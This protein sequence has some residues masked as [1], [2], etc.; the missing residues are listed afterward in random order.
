M[1]RRTHSR[2]TRLGL[3]VIVL[4]LT[5]AYFLPK[6]PWQGRSLSHSHMSTASS[7][8]VKD[9]WRFVKRAERGLWAER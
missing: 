6:P 7:S 3:L 9:E 5:L 4:L 1:T 8:E 2:R